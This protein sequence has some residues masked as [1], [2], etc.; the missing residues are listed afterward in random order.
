MN[1]AIAIVGMACIYPDARTPGELWEN[2]LAQRRAFRRMPAER[3][4]LEDYFASDPNASD[5]TYST[6]AAVIEGYEFDRV[7]F[8]VAGSTFRSADLAHWLALD[9]AARALADAGF[10]DGHG[11]P[12]EA[13]GVL[14]GN[15]LTGEQSRANTL[16]LRWP[17]VRRVLDAALAKEKWTTGQRQKFLSDLEAEYKSPFPP[18][19]EETLA[20]SLSN[21]IAGRICNQFD[22]KGGGYTIDGACASSLLAIANACSSLAAGDLDVAIAGGIDLSLDPFEI[23]GFAKTGALAPDEMRVYDKRSAGFWPGEGCG[24]VVLMRHDDALPQGRR[25]YAVIRG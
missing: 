22:L 7:G 10:S 4:R 6:E 15:T 16:R 11:L 9:V 2:A 12:R 8:R 18:V 23:V 1:S 5:A 21:T 3:L 25:V 19:G 24:M 14:L 17:Y 20:G 13:T